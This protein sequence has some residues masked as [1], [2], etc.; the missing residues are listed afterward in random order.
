VRDLSYRDAL[1]R[2]ASQPTVNIEG[3]YAGYT[4]P[5]GKTI[6]PSKAT[7][8]LDFRLSGSRRPTELIRST[9]TGETVA[10]ERLTSAGRMLAPVN[11]T[12]QE[13]RGAPLI[14]RYDDSGCGSSRAG[15]RPLS[16]STLPGIF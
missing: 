11:I 6:L 5:G 10:V 3:M 12:T 8:K 7:A 15:A 2:L 14:C 16:E 4:G 13:I 1:E 9:A